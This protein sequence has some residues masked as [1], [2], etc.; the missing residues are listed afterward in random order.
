MKL[1]EFITNTVNEYLNKEQ[2][3]TFVLKKIKSFKTNEGNF[4]IY[5]I[6]D[7]VRNRVN[8]FTVL[9]DKNGWI[10]RNAFV[11]DELQ[12][13]GIATDFYIKMNQKSKE[14]TGKS[15][16]STQ[17]RTLSNG[18]IV[19]ELSSNGIALWDSFVDKGLAVKLG[20]KNYIFK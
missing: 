11:P 4:S 13:K 7:D 10:I 12:R 16:R 18:E 17:Q 3:D 15:L 20:H 8:I 2:N 1:K 19:H 6:S 9:E 5:D 14:K